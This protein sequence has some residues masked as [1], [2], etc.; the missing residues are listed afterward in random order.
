MPT[1]SSPSP[2]SKE[3]PLAADAAWIRQWYGELEQQFGD[4]HRSLGFN[5][6]ASQQKRFEALCEL[7]DF[8]GRRLLDVGCGLGHFLLFLRE[9]GVHPEYTG[10]DITP[11]LIGHARARFPGEPSRQCS[12]DVGDTLTYE[13]Q[14]PFDFVVAS[15]IFGLLST[16]AEERIAPTMRRLFSWATAGM[17]IN[18]LSN[19]STRQAD[20]RLYVDPSRM[21]SL[22]LELTP[23]VRLHH[24]YLPNDFTLYLYKTPAWA[25]ESQA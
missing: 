5:Q 14:K 2:L 22:A 17:A 21:L 1:S 8:N 7:G 10:L 9:R 12:F 3:T 24:N 15:G 20:G 6:R 18:F 19:R 11:E 25:K 23:A 4:D 16:H 13:P